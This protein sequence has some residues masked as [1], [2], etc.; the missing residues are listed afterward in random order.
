MK[1][2]ER[3]E[4]RKGTNNEAGVFFSGSFSVHS[5]FFYICLFF[6]AAFLAAFFPNVVLKKIEN[7]LIFSRK[8]LR[9]KERGRTDG[10]AIIFNFNQNL[11]LDPPSFDA[12][13]AIIAAAATCPSCS[14]ETNGA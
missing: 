7:L 5:F 3:R 4:E 2:S 11:D 10:C 8:H 13:F 1:W 14:G 6:F 12:S 9:E